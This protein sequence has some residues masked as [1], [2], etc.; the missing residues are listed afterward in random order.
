MPSLRWILRLTTPLDLVIAGVLT[1]AAALETA[2]ESGTTSLRV[3]LAALTV[4]PLAARRTAPAL[5]AGLIAVGLAAES[6]ATES[7]DQAG[8]LLAI[9]IS[10]YSVAAHAERREAILGLGLLG[11][12]ISASIA[13]DPSDDVSN[14]LPTLAL[15][16]AIPAGL[17][18]SF[19]RRGRELVKLELRAEA[20]EQEAE[21][22]LESERRRIARE[23]HDVVSHAVTL[24]AVQAEAGQALLDSDPAGTR[25]SLAAISAASRDAVAELHS[26]LSVM[27][28]PGQSVI[29]TGLRDL[30]A[31]V[32]GVRAAGLR[33][34][35]EQSGTDAGRSQDID[36]CA[37]RTVQEGLTNSLRHARNPKVDLTISQD[38]TSL[39]VRI[40]SRGAP[41]QSTYGGSGR[42]LAGLRERVTAL[43]GTLET[44]AEGDTFTLSARLPVTTP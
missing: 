18:F 40:D 21:V 20:A 37:Y 27:G 42:G 30:P 6:F 3:V 7:P 28:E 1:V 34:T 33:V 15:F 44:A 13:V 10:A 23:L 43:G 17:G 8:V 12:A 9:V 22:A 5:S 31:L 14:I 24:I 38:E 19:R 32:A 29:T 4:L 39:E 2:N 36:H 35:V 25:R 11:M 26:M 41:H 16:V